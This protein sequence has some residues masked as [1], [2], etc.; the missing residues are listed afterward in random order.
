MNHLFVSYSRKDE[1][2]VTAVVQLLRSEGFDVW[3]DISGKTSGIPYSTKWFAAIEEALYTSAGAVTFESE[4]WSKSNPCKQERALIDNLSIPLFKVDFEGDADEATPE[5]LAAQIAKWART[6]VYSSEENDLRTWILSSVHASQMQKGRYTGIPHFKKRKDAKAFLERLKQCRESD[7]IAG[8]AEKNPALHGEISRFLNRARM[9]TIWNRCKKPLAILVVLAIL[10]SIAWVTEDYGAKKRHADANLAALQIMDSVNDEIDDDEVQALSLMASDDLQLNEYTPKLF[11]AYA[12]VLSRPYPCDFYP[13]DSEEAR[14][15]AAMPA[16]DTL[17]GYEVAL[18][19]TLGNVTV[20][21]NPDDDALRRSI[22]YHTAS[23]PGAYALKDGYLAVA[24][25]QQVYVIDLAR[26]YRPVE[27]RYC[28]RNIAGIRFDAAGRICATTSFGD[29]YVWDNPIA[30]IAC[31]A[32]DAPTAKLT[33]AECVSGSGAFIA[34]GLAS[35]KL[36]VR[37]SLNDCAIWNC[38]A[39]TEP[40]EAVYLDES[41]WTVYARGISGAFYAADASAVL[42][43]YSADDIAKQRDNYRALGNEITNRLGYGLGIAQEY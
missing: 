43:S 8:F 9:V 39:I 33:A 27:L 40:I 5:T 7:L 29:V 17:E 19:E 41:T 6:D 36:E 16:Q 18:S 10:G 3:Q 31:K 4:A 24:S 21:T 37:D 26:G 13:Q 38:I 28:Y 2:L 11:E 35:G 1:A 25:A 20:I 22:V 42:A 14:A 23:A 32:E 15:V 30:Q 34:R 12:D